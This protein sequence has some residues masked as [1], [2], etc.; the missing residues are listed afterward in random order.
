MTKKYLQFMETYV[1]KLQ[2]DFNKFH[3]KVPGQEWF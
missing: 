1:I 3:A 2:R